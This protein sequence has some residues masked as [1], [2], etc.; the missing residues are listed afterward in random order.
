MEGTT[1]AVPVEL[2]H[3]LKPEEGWLTQVGIGVLAHQIALPD[4]SMPPMVVLLMDRHS[5]TADQRSGHD[6]QS[7]LDGDEVSFVC[8]LDWEQAQNLSVLAGRAAESVDKHEGSARVPAFVAKPLRA[9]LPDVME[10]TQVGITVRPVEAEGATHALAAT[11][12]LGDALEY[13]VAGMGAP[14]TR[15]LAGFLARYAAKVRVAGR[16]RRVQ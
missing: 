7:V 16:A 8:A 10:W 11:L 6:R 4:H 9:F 14:A 12:V 5:V 3:A 1:P 15:T 2:V 13:T